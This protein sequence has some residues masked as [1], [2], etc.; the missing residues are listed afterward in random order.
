MKTELE[1]KR[2]RLNDWINQMDEEGLDQL[3]EEYLT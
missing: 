1:E 3:I 2:E